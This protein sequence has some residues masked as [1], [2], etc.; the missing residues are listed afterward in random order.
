MQERPR[1]SIV[2]RGWFLG[3]GT[4][5]V[6]FIFGGAGS[7]KTHF[8]LEWIA[9]QL[10][11]DPDGSPIVLLV[12]EQATYQMERALVSRRGLKGYKRAMVVSFAWLA[13][14]GL[15]AGGAGDKLLGDTIRQMMLQSLLDRIADQLQLWKGS[16]SQSGFAVKILAA[17]DEL[18]D[19]GL[20]LTDLQDLHKRQLDRDPHGEL[21]AKLGDLV[22]IYRGY[23]DALPTGFQDRPAALDLFNNATEKLTWLAGATLLVDGFSGF[24]RQEYAALLAIIKRCRKSFISLCLDPECLSGP[25]AAGGDTFGQILQTYQRL[26]QLLGHKQINIGPPVVLARQGRRRFRQSSVLADIEAGLAGRAVKKSPLRADQ[27]LDKSLRI[28]KLPSAPDEVRHAADTILKLVADGYRFRDIAVIVR[29]L[30]QFQHLI[31]RTFHQYD[32]PFFLDVRRPVNRHPLAAL[33]INALRGW[34]FD[35]RSSDVLAYLKTGLAGL[36][37]QQADR[38][39]NMALANGIQGSSWH[40]GHWPGS[41]RII[42]RDN[43]KDDNHP[44]D[45][46]PSD[47]PA[48]W[49][50]LAIEP[51]RE[52]QL[53]LM[54]DDDL[55]GSDKSFAVGQLTDAVL[56]L[57]RRLEVPARLSRWASDLQR[58]GDVDQAQV[59]VQVWREFLKFTEQLQV[60][61]GGGKFTL[62]QFLSL[63][64]LAFDRLTVGVV[65]SGLDQVL[66]GSVERSRHPAVRA[67]LVLGFNEGAFPAAASEDRILTDAER[68]GL[69]LPD[70]PLRAQP[71]EHLSGEKFLAYIA[72]TR[73]SQ[74]LQVSF[75]AADAQGA[76]L[77]ES[78]YLE[79]LRESAGRDD[80]HELPGGPVWLRPLQEGQYLHPADL[81]A[82]LAYHV[83]RGFDSAHSS[84]LWVGAYNR[85]L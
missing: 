51:L 20:T 6:R 68:A 17:I 4:M 23:R 36:D 65:P 26:V 13:R 60:A 66:V 40:E 64:V 48:A 85:M 10:R 76:R 59:H 63:L 70:L 56:R 58:T 73:P 79:H 80:L 71:Q 31:S 42:S 19:A 75:A 72:L 7:G 22:C 8:C 27:Q 32:I 30:D 53:R 37:R 9:R 61:L 38:L 3:E 16:A 55:S 49:R 54:G 50:E 83:G 74:F 34:A 25:T 28:V 84:D 11:L 24:T 18:Q 62:E 39:E 57:I 5:Q 41:G 69:G 67:A 47:D 1:G 12:P 2:A 44:A 21:A 46:R 14:E 78:R 52:A 35:W 81:A 82:A 29:R 45:D 15:T 33:V 43:N 77:S